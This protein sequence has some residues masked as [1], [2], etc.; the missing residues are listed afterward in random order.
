MITARQSRAA[1]ALLG[2]TQET[3][4]DAARVSLTALKRLE[5]ESGLEVYESTRDQ[6]RR[7]LEAAGIVLLSTDKG[8]GVLLLNERNMQAR[9]R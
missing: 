8:E 9:S 1:R 4:A 3:L 7:A 6:V 5:S 2:W